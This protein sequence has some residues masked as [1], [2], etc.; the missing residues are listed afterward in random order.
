MLRGGGILLPLASLPGQYGIGDLGRTARRFIDFLHEAGITYWQILPASPV[1]YGYSPYQS[2]SAFA[3]NEWLIDLEMMVEPGW[4]REDR[5]RSLGRAPDDDRIHYGHVRE[6]KELLLREAFIN[7]PP[8]MRAG[9]QRYA[10][11]EDSWLKDYVRF[12]AIKD[13]YKGRPWYQ[14][15]RDIR[16]RMPDALRRYDEMLAEEMDF[17]RFCQYMFFW[18]WELLKT[19]AHEKHIKIIGDLPLYVSADSADIWAYTDLFQL[20]AT[21]RPAPVAGCPPDDFTPDGQIWGNPL[22]Q[23]ERMA[24]NKYTWWAIRMKKARWMYDYIRIDHFRG[25]EAYWAVPADARSA[26]EGHWVQGPGE[27]FFRAIHEAIGP[28]PWIAEDLGHLT[29]SVHQLRD[30]LGIPGMRVLQF[31]FDG[32]SDNPY[33]PHNYTPH[34]V[35]Y[36]GTHDNDTAAGWLAGAPADQRKKAIRYLALSPKETYHWGFIRGAW[37]SVANVAIAPMQ[38][39]LGLGSEARINKP[40]TIG[41]N[42]QWMLKDHHLTPDLATKIREINQLYGR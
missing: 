9:V 18:Q 2:P 10:E 7:T 26:V 28:V 41:D 3:G 13:Y 12:R 19:Y 37:A 35:A 8:A 11:T 36:T 39:F 33:L 23:W 15:P 31:A 22:Y 25:F 32:D 27:S 17:Y 14:W 20:D 38:D 34:C 42:W 24:E 6:K 4:L 1:G 40:G 21:G 30:K 29:A 16:H 5:L